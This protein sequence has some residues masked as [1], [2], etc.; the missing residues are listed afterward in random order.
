MPSNRLFTLPPFLSLQFRFEKIR[1]ARHYEAAA[2]ILIR[3]AVMTARNFIKLR[4]VDPLPMNTWVTVEASARIDLSGGWSDTPPITYEHG[5]SVVNAAIV[6]D[7]K[8]SM[9][10]R[11]RRIPEFHI[12][13]NMVGAPS[14]VK[15]M[16]D[17]GKWKKERGVKGGLKQRVCLC[18][19]SFCPHPNIALSTKRIVIENIDQL[20]NYTQPQAPGALLKAVS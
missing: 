4:V 20:R 12:V 16:K 7:G 9:G 10:A 5:G 13:L 3:H 11:A 2:Q 19:F 18:F 1:A 6:I 15:P 14:Q 8:R 17:L